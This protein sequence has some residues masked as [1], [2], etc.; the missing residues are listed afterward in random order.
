MPRPRSYIVRI[1][2]RQSIERVDGIVEIVASGVLVPFGS[3]DELWS[4]VVR[5]RGPAGA[6]SRPGLR[7]SASNQT[8]KL[9]R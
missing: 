4:I 9:R 6:R 3:A 7:R 1:Y 5:A 8:G 2:T